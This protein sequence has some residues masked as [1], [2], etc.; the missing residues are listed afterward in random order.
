MTMQAPS[1]RV[2]L[3]RRPERGSY[4]PDA[5]AAILDEAFVGHL[6]LVLDGQGEA[7]WKS[8]EGDRP[9]ARRRGCTGPATGR[10]AAGIASA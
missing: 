9:G 7:R 8:G 10:D 5:I 2:R 1:E 4:D 6:G 3:R